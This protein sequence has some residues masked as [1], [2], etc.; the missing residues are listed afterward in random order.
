LKDGVDRPLSFDV[1][2]QPSNSTEPTAAILNASVENEVATEGIHSVNTDGNTS[3]SNKLKDISV[4]KPIRKKRK[5]LLAMRGFLGP[6]RKSLNGNSV[7]ELSVEGSFDDQPFMMSRDKTG[8]LERQITVIERP[9]FS[10]TSSDT[11]SPIRLETMEKQELQQQS[12]VTERA[13]RLSTPPSSCLLENA[14]LFEETARLVRC[15]LIKTGE[16]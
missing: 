10:V 15:L 5:M 1:K 7:S 2:L 13:E 3:G 8:S 6:N 16:K 11:L 12:A 14:A 9:G 4:E